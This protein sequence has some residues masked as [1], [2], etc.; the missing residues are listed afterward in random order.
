MLLYILGQARPQ[1]LPVALHACVHPKCSKTWL[2]GALWTGMLQGL[3]SQGTVSKCRVR[4]FLAVGR[5]RAYIFMAVAIVV[6]V[7][8][9]Y[10]SAH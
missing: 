3:A 5:A 4:W 10:G 8:V 2:T 7:V 6:A 1:P 9:S